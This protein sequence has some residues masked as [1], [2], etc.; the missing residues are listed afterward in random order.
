MMMPMVVVL[1]RGTNKKKTNDFKITS[2]LYIGE[3][4]RKDIEKDFH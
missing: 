1:P 3:E 2:H 4:Q